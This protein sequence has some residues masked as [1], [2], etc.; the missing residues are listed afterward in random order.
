MARLSVPTRK[1]KQLRICLVA[2]TYPPEVGGGETQARMLAGGLIERGCEVFVLTRRSQ[3][4]LAREERMGPVPVR[5]LAPAGRG[6]LKKWGLAVSAG[7]ALV[8][9]R[10]QYDVVLACP[11]RILG[12]P[13][14]LVTGML[15]R[16]CIL[17]AETNGEMSGAFFTPG[18]ARLGLPG[19]S[20][21]VR[22]MVR[23]RNRILKRATVF[24][25]LSSAIETE[26]R[27]HGVPPDAIHRIPNGVDAERFRPPSAD[28]RQARRHALGI[29]ADDSVFAFTGR[30][31]SYKG[32][33]VLL[34]AWE[35]V[36]STVPSAR[37]LLIGSG[38]ADIHSCESE[39]RRYVHTHGLEASVT[40]V[41][42]TP[43]VVPYLHAADA[44]VFPTE[45]EAFGIALIEAM[46]CGLPV[47][48]TPVGGIPDIVT[49]ERDAILV[50]PGDPDSL[51]SAIVRLHA[52]PELA[53]RLGRA[54]RETVTARYAHT[55]V[56]GRYLDLLRH[57][58]DSVR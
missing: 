41:G 23:A 8:R 18:L 14:V 49:P 2:E 28:E 27:E 6:Q 46:A 45:K 58:A 44:F 48:T 21:V 36:R 35:A 40:F 53:S 57:H 50:R 15:G 26:L 1:P 9:T 56:V 16:P 5:R 24:V 37:L 4:A 32:L 25:A 38:G 51:C 19:A 10:R 54:A 29:A 20:W 34:R 42:E 22:L 13:A 7:A 17:K 47:I 12:V 52:D 39:L 55:T 30:L 31:V 33:P 11:F 3:H 43:D